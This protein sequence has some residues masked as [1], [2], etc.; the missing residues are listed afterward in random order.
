[1]LLPLPLLIYAHAD[2]TPY[3]ML[4]DAVCCSCCAEVR[5]RAFC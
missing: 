1:M 4:R 3:A 5:V 2:A